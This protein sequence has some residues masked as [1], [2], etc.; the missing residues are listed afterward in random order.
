MF[1]CSSVRKRVGLPPAGTRSLLLRLKESGTRFCK[2][3]MR[4]QGE[5]NVYYCSHNVMGLRM[6]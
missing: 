6:P 3:G 4:R 5:V 2:D 1:Y